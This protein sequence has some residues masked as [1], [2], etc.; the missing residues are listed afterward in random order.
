VTPADWAE[1]SRTPQAVALTLAIGLAYPLLGWWRFRR[2]E[3]R[4]E[5]VARGVKLRLYASIVASQWTLVALTAIVLAGSGLGLADLGQGPGASLARTAFAALALLAGFA[6]LSRLTLVQLARASAD[7]LPAHVRRAGRILPAGGIERAGF[8][9]VAITAGVCEEILY[10]GWLPWAV[11]GWTGS[12]AAGFV[13]AALVFGAGH[14]YQGRNGMI[15]T[16]LLG[17]FLGGVVAWTGSLLPGQ[18]LHV[19][20]DLVN[21]LAV[22]AALERHRAPPPPAEPASRAAPEPAPSSAELPPHVPV[23]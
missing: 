4:P 15:L 21:G 9:P 17:L 14:A 23:E 19:A 3:R 5:P 10:R 22:G 2:L 12:A 13:L 8:V 1:L 7:E 20:V 6:V 18:F 11:A 16:A